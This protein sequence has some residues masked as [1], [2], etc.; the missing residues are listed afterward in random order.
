MTGTLLVTLSA[1]ALFTSVV[2][3]L[4]LDTTITRDIPYFQ[5]LLI[6]LS[7][8][9]TSTSMVELSGGAGE[10]IKVSNVLGTN[11]LLKAPI[12]NV[13]RVNQ[14]YGDSFATGTLT[15]N[16]FNFDILSY[17]IGF[18]TDGFSDGSC[19]SGEAII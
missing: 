7:G 16:L 19:A 4:T 10:L 2:H 11:D 3:A 13:I 8:D 14:L 12:G 17:H 9:A 18:G 1:A 5:R 6:T 15:T